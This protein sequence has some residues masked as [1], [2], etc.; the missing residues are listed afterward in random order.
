MPRLALS[1]LVAAMGL[2]SS[3]AGPIPGA[4]PT[5]VN[6][7]SAAL[8]AYVAALCEGV[9]SSPVPRDISVDLGGGVYRMDAPLALSRDLT[10]TGMIRV[11]DGTLLAGAGL[12]SPAVVAA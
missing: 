4:D 3:A 9:S 6:D 1:L 8:N 2:G 11:H 10:C 5:G 7:S 12:A